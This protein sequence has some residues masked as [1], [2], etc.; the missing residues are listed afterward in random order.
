[1]PVRP[2]VQLQKKCVLF[3]SIQIPQINENIYIYIRW[4]GE[5]LKKIINYI[6]L[7]K[8]VFT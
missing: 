1:M 6:P 3:T 2:F 5:T 7:F 4:F 8:Q